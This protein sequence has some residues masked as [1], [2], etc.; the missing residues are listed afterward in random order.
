M[1]PRTLTSRMN[2]LSTV[3]RRGG[4]GHPRGARRGGKNGGGGKDDG[5]SNGGKGL[6]GRRTSSRRR[7]EEKTR[8]P[9]VQVMS[10]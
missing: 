9:Q 5:K 2:R 1:S 7:M 8:S 10:S 4:E 6:C 3:R